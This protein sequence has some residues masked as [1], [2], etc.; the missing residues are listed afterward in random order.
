[1]QI[2]DFIFYTEDGDPTTILVGKVI[3]IYDDSGEVRTD[4]D[5][6]QQSL[7]VSTRHDWVWENGKYVLPRSQSM[8]RTLRTIAREIRADWV[9]PNYAAVPY[10]NAMA[11]MD[12]AKDAFG[13]DPGKEVVLYFLNNA[14]SWRGEKA[15]AIKAE[16]KKMVGIK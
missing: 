16:L 2:N 9:K 12:G 11:T 4:S 13:N 7:G 15:R 14:S 5:G 3:G 6:M 1:M 8:E 10:L